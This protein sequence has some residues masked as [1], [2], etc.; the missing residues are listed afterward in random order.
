LRQRRIVGGRE[1]AIIVA[2]DS[3]LQFG[4]SPCDDGSKLFDNAIKF[5]ELCDKLIKGIACK[6]STVNDFLR[7]EC[8]PLVNNLRI[9]TEKGCIRKAGVSRLKEVFD[10][11]KISVAF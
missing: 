7:C 5:G 1:V 9:D 6:F 11:V 10:V 4:R 2:A 8:E 3:R